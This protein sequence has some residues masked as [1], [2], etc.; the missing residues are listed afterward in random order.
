MAAH[1]VA[2]ASSLPPVAWHIS[3]RSGSGGGNCVEAGPT[4]DGSGRVAV[5][6][7]RHPHGRVLVYQAESWTA[8]VVGIRAGC[9]DRPQQC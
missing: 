7:S 1:P 8:F 2:T 6:H 4:L 9:F 3:T 5:R